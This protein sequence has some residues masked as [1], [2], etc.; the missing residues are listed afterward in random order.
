MNVFIINI[1][2][3][4]F[5]LKGLQCWQFEGGI[6]AVKLLPKTVECKLIGGVGRIGSQLLA[7]PSPH[8]TYGLGN[9]THGAKARHPSGQDTLCSSHDKE[10]KLL[11]ALE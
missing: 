9:R 5:I 3:S 8:S 4:N 2:S 10:D 6:R 7:P 11:E 1:K